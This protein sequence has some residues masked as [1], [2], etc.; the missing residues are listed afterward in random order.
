MSPSYETIRHSRVELL[1]RPLPPVARFT[2]TTCFV[3]ADDSMPDCDILKWGAERRV[4][5][6]V[7]NVRKYG[8]S[9]QRAA[10]R[11]NIKKA[12]VTAPLLFSC[13]A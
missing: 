13:G 7:R 6:P 5:E 8:T 3:T 9:K 1:A 4:F 2:G 10:A 11:R 12:D